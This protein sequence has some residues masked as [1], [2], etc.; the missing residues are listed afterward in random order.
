MLTLIDK[1]ILVI[2][3]IGSWSSA[4]QPIVLI[5]ILSTFFSL[6]LKKYPTLLISHV[7][8]G[9][10]KSVYLLNICTIC[11]CFASLT[12]LFSFLF[13]S[14]YRVKII[15]AMIWSPHNAMPEKC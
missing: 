8:V 4:F 12:V 5:F 1:F 13:A 10:S 6:G 2:V 11:T 7:F 14:C 15:S 9:Q 3:I